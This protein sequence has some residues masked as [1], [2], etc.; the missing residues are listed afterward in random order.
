MKKYLVGL[1]LL[2]TGAL[3]LAGV[4]GFFVHTNTTEFCIS[5]HTM[6][7][8]HDEYR[9]TV[10]YKN[11][12]GVQTQ[13]ADCHVPVDFLPRLAAKVNAVKDI[14]HQLVGTVD[15]R[16]K[17]EARRWDMANRVWARMK[18]SDSREC[19]SCHQL[20]NMALGEQSRSARKRHEQAPANGKT[21]IDCH[22]GVVHQLP[23]EPDETDGEI[24]DGDEAQDDEA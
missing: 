8:N 6:Q 11:R 21:C 1:A 3:A 17:F 2:A 19:R 10:H 13:C 5:C 14:Y 9:E 7:G 23:D 22:K 4:N 24:A 18:A 16:D 20:Q 15:T 12:S